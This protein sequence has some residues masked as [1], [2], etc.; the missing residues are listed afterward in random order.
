[1]TTIKIDTIPKY[2]GDWACREDIIN[3]LANFTYS[4]YY[5]A[6]DRLDWLESNSSF[7]TEEEILYAR[8]DTPSYEGYAV[9][10]FARGGK[11]F[12]YE[13]S[14]CSCN[15]LEKDSF[16]YGE[17]SWEAITNRYDNGI[18]WGYCNAADPE[19]LDA[20]AVLVDTHLQ[21]GN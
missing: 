5:G 20:L 15:G 21:Q 7:P 13:D 1:M 6:Q 4:S 12:I 14:H 10:L 2:F 18:L 16:S 8:Y 9:I 11:L 17:T 19:G 3:S